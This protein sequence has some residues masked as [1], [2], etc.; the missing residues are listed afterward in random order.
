M[1]GPK[2]EIYFSDGSSMK[3]KPNGLTPKMDKKT[4]QD[5]YEAKIII[6]HNIIHLLQSIDEKLSQDEERRTNQDDWRQVAKVLDRLLMII[7]LF[8]STL[9][10]AK[11]I[12]YW[13]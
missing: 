6:L 12:M 3:F 13:K 4:L 5:F 2:S 9:L 8:I 10:T 1:S 11:L 7:F